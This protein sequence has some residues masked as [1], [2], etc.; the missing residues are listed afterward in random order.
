MTVA[1]IKKIAKANGI[2]P[3]KLRK[4]ELVKAIQEAE[5]NNVCFQGDFAEVCKISECLWFNDCADRSNKLDL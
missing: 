4:S 2:K 3:K 5:G 1:E